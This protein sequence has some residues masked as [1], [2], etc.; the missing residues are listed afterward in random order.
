MI[1]LRHELHTQVDS[2]LSFP[3][4]NLTERLAILLEVGHGEIVDLVL[5]QKA[6]HLHA[7]LETK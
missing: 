2:V 6:V 1:L 7:R 4:P 3:R 5:L